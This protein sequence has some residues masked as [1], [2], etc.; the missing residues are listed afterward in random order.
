MSHAWL[1]VAVLSL[2]LL[3]CSSFIVSNGGGVGLNGLNSAQHNLLRNLDIISPFRHHQL[4]LQR[5]TDTVSTL[6]SST[7]LFSVAPNKGSPLSPDDLQILYDNSTGSLDSTL[8]PS[9]GASRV[10]ATNLAPSGPSS[11]DPLIASLQRSRKSLVNCPQIWSETAK[12]VPN[13]PA[14]VDNYNCD[15][16]IT[17]TFREME[18]MVD[19]AS[20]VFR[21]L[22][23]KRG[24]NAA[25]FGEVSVG[26][27]ERAILR[28]T[29][30]SERRH[31]E[32]SIIYP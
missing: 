9:T 32:R 20:N 10:K 21:S 2:L 7:T 8:A 4:P 3:H 6:K 1:L 28:A 18:E 29:T 13:S 23:V 19:K 25:I 14:L 31:S 26:R 30:L 22:G 24:V 17:Y 15:V 5:T 12:H 16:K 11:S 27:R